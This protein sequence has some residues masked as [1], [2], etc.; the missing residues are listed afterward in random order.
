MNA[1]TVLPGE[2]Q[3]RPLE[4]QRSRERLYYTGRRFSGPNSMSC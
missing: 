3:D 4:Q 1:G 2:V